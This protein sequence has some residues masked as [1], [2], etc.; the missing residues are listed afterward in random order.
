MS[1]D[2]FFNPNQDRVQ[3]QM[4]SLTKE[5]AD[6]LWRQG[7]H[8]L[9]RE[10]IGVDRICPGTSLEPLLR[11]VRTDGSSQPW[12]ETSAPP[13]RITETESSSDDEDETPVEGLARVCAEIE[14]ISDETD[15]EMDTEHEPPEVNPTEEPFEVQE[16]ILP[17]IV[18]RMNE[19]RELFITEEL[20]GEERE[21]RLERLERL[22]RRFQEAEI[23]IDQCAHVTLQDPLLLL[24]AQLRRFRIGRQTFFCPE[25]SCRARALTSPGEMTLHIQREHGALKQETEDMVR[26]FI[27][28]FL[29]RRGC[30]T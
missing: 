20:E 1:S 5:G 13:E 9:G 27:A 28:R 22:L 29:P 17:E 19:L 18:E 21:P 16:G 15:S 6:A 24:L 3:V 26:Y 11:R 8:Q 2:I 12:R 10:D 30:A 14:T 25:E 23:P 7:E 4:A